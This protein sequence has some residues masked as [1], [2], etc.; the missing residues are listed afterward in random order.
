M[1][2]ATLTGEAGKISMAAVRRDD[3]P[4]AIEAV[5]HNRPETAD[6]LDRSADGKLPQS[7]FRPNFPTAFAARLVL[8]RFPPSAVT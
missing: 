7:T 2:A 6:A 5:V 3:R 4:A 8:S 1:V